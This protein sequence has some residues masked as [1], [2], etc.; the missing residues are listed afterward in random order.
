MLAFFIPVEC[1]EVP[2]RGLNRYRKQ[3]EHNLKSLKT[4]VETDLLS[5]CQR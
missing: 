5:H 3:I 4:T 2:G 1:V